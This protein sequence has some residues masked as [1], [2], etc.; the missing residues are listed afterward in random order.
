LCVIDSVSKQKQAEPMGD[1][2]SKNQRSK[3]GQN[4]ITS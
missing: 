4:K 2:C 1:A 3:L